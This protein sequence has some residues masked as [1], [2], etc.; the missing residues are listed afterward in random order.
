MKVFV[1]VAESG[2]LS[3]A[4]RALDMSN[5]SV[6]RH[7]ADLEAYLHARLFNRS[8]R[9]LSLT[10]TGAAY[11]ERC[12]Q[13]LQDLEDA[14]L[15][16][17]M[18]AARPA[19]TLRVN[20]P[21]SFAVNYLARALPEYAARYPEVKLDLTLSDRVVDLIEE[22]YDVAI[23]I[24]RMPDSSALVARQIA[25]ARNLVCAAP[26]YL[27]RCGAPSTPEELE[28]HACLTYTYLASRDEWQFM[29]DGKLH[30]ARVRGPLVANNGDLL[31][32]AAIAGMGIIVKPSF[33][34]GDAIRQKRLVPLLTDYTMPDLP[35]FAVYPS[36]RH[37]SAK[38]RT[39][40]DFLVERY[41]EHPDWDRDLDE[42]LSKRSTPRK[43]KP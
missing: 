41:R 3:A 37:L 35:I 14:A 33:I 34:I 17:S 27:K 39:F 28:Q 9:R 4:A 19:G 6:T 22:G 16:A 42:S 32:E 29:R 36:R 24:S 1:K 43:G 12:R 10:E 11:L 8:T 20:A 21:V 31:R 23:R 18:S 5:P 26:S 40:V 25:S 15:A 13:L 38:V 2:S 30:V 7:V